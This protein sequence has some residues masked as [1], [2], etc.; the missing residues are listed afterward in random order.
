CRGR[1]HL[2]HEDAGAHIGRNLE[3]LLLEYG[4]NSSKLRSRCTRHEVIEGDEAVGLA[5]TEA[6][7]QLNDG[8]SLGAREP[9][10]GNPD[11]IP[12]AISDVG[13]SEEG[14]WVL[15]FIVR[16]SMK[17]LIEVGGELS[18]LKAALRHIRMGRDDL[19]PW[20]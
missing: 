8:I 1:D 7:L 16:F 13:P 3:V 9:V 14:L 20:G 4:I 11:Q 15:I 12:E 19:P 10:G 18:L 6:R 5:T 2:P 17:H